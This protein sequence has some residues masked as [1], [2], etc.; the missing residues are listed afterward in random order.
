MIVEEDR[1]RYYQNPYHLFPEIAATETSRKNVI[2]GAIFAPFSK[3]IV[4]DDMAGI[5]ITRRF[6]IPVRVLFS[7][8]GVT[9]GED[10]SDRRGISK[11]PFAV[12]LRRKRRRK[13]EKLPRLFGWPGESVYGH[14][15]MTWCRNNEKLFSSMISTLADHEKNSGN[16]VKSFAMSPLVFSA[17][18][19]L[20][21]SVVFIFL[22][23]GMLLLNGV[24]IWA[25]RRKR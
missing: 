7:K 8:V 14:G 21:A 1:E 2:N 20:A 13:T 9:N 24:V 5:S 18:T 4:L 11:V 3:R 19:V 25:S 15:Q 23:P 6:W 17:Q 16:T 10:Y 12:C 22:L